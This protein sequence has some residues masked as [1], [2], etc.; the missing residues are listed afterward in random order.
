[1]LTCLNNYAKNGGNPCIAWVL[2]VETCYKRYIK[3]G[4]FF[5]ENYFIKVREKKESLKMGYAIFT[6]RKFTLTSRINQC[7][8]RAMLLSER[9][10]SLTNQIYA[11][12]NA[13]NQAVSAATAKAYKQYQASVDAGVEFNV[14]KVDLDEAL[15]KID[16]DSIGTDTEIQ[17][18]NMA[19]TAMDMERQTLETQLNAYQKELENVKKAEETAI[20]NS[21]PKFS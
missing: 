11:K 6:L 2:H 12:Q 4:N 10:N 19:Q 3:K 15:A 8:T 17:N 7:N 13:K 9:A 16:A 20:K 5:K 1:L 14:A 21:T 18:L